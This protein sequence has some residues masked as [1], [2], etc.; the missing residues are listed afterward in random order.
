MQVEDEMQ[1]EGQKL[2]NLTH[3]DVAVGGEEAAM[4]LKVIGQQRC[5]RSLTQPPGSR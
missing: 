5:F 2:P 1:V 3:P 4:V